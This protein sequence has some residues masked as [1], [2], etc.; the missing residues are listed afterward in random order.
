MKVLIDANIALSKLLNRSAFF[1]GSNAI[2]RLAEAG[3]IAGYIS[4]SAVTDIYCIARKSLGKTAAREAIKKMLPVFRPADV[5]DNHIFK[6]LELEWAGFEDSVQSAVG[7]SLAVDCPGRSP[8]VRPRRLN[9]EN[10]IQGDPQPLKD[11]GRNRV[12]AFVDAEAQVFREAVRRKLPVFGID[13]PV[14][15]DPRRPVKAELPLHF[16]GRV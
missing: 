13:Y 9:V 4:A 14:L 16:Y 15:A 8:P 3:Q 2:L 1:A 5:T 11:R 6:A 7:E 12:A 10:L